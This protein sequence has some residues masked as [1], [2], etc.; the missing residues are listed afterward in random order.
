MSRI[1]ISNARVCLSCDEIHTD[2][3]CPYCL[4]RQSYPLKKWIIPMRVFEETM[5]YMK[6]KKSEV[7]E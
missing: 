7:V 4:D 6:R 2:D 3:E 5:K 1:K